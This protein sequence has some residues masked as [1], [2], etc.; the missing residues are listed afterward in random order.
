MITG[1]NHCTGMIGKGG[2]S[3]GNEMNAIR[4]HGGAGEGVR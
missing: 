3:G 2:V 1:I 4:A